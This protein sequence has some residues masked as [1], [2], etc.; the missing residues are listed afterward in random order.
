MK[1]SLNVKLISDEDNLNIKTTGIKT[2]NTIIYK[3][4]DINV[5]IKLLN[6]KIEMNRS[7]KDYNI[8]L[9]FEKNKKTISTY[10]LFGTS[11]EFL[12][13]TKTNKLLIQENKL[14]VDYELEGNKF[15]FCIEFG[16]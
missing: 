15:M 14:S 6:N 4:N 10:K 8:N 16:G 3:E 5:I 13:E 7:C 2:K 12:L 1:I 11:K 9:I